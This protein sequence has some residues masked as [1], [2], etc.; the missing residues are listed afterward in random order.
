MSVI[1]IGDAA[2]QPT[3]FGMKPMLPRLRF[4]FAAALI[5]ALPWILLGSGIVT[6]AQNPP[7]SEQPRPGQGVTIAAGDLRD[8]QHMHVLAF[9]RRS[10]ELE[11]LRELASAPLSDWIATPSGPSPSDAA[12]APADTPAQPDPAVSTAEPTPAPQTVASLPVADDTAPD[13]ANVVVPLPAVTSNPEKESAVAPASVPT[14]AENSQDAAPE[15]TQNAAAPPVDI[16]P[17]LSH[18]DWSKITPPLPRARTGEGSRKTIVRRRGKRH[19]S[20]I[21]QGQ[22]Q[23]SSNPFGLY[24]DPFAGPPAT[25]TVNNSAYGGDSIPQ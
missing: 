14:A 25:A 6:T 24:P 1:R 20:R 2:G 12:A 19:V 15:A 18:A 9:V 16:G 11:R 17:G 4:V 21:P 22:M 23:A 10:R 5:A 7:I 3:H 8:A 13:E